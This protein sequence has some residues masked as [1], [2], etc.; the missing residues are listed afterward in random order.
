MST[1]FGMGVFSL[2]AALIVEKIYGSI[3]HSTSAAA[4]AGRYAAFTGTWTT[5]G[6][7]SAVRGVRN[8]VRRWSGRARS[9]RQLI[10]KA[11]ED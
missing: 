5:L 1:F 8:S 2:M 3:V 7:A 10:E 6:T 4:E 11:K 9:T